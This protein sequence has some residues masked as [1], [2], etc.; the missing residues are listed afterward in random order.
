MATTDLAHTQRQVSL[1]DFISKVSTRISPHNQNWLL[2]FHTTVANM[3]ALLPIGAYATEQ[4]AQ[5]ART[6][7]NIRMGFNE[8]YSSV[9]APLGQW[10]SVDE[11][12]DVKQVLEASFYEIRRAQ[13]ERRLGYQ[14]VTPEVQKI[15]ERIRNAPH[16]PLP[17][18]PNVDAPERKAEKPEDDPPA[19]PPVAK[20][21]G[22]DVLPPGTAA[23]ADSAGCGPV[24]KQTTLTGTKQTDAE[25]H[26][27]EDSQKQLQSALDALP[28]EDAK[29]MVTLLHKKL[30]IVLQSTPQSTPERPVYKPGQQEAFN[31]LT[32]KQKVVLRRRL[33][34]AR[35]T[36]NQTEIDAICSSFGPIVVV[37]D[38][39]IKDHG[40]PQ[41]Q[42]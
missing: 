11:G 26:T 6:E 8:K 23:P 17:A 28:V 2:M 37:D 4:Q 16:L 29:L 35:R 13:E 21:K 24:E 3:T 9:I 5:D 20:M 40:P 36:N 7:L 22:S 19:Q 14:G 30:G 1:T 42:T 32:P 34:K 10:G 39:E 31:A 25:W 38:S 33:L 27:P 18:L 41:A 15:L 12:A